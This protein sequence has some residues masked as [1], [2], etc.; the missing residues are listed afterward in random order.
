MDGLS[1]TPSVNSFAQKIKADALEL[2][3]KIGTRS[4][5]AARLDLSER[6]VR[7]YELSKKSLPEFYRLAIVGLAVELGKKS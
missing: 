4:Q 6:T 2:R 7:R 1:D 5:V 3:E